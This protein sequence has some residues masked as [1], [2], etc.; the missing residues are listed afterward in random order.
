MR[1]LNAASAAIEGTIVD[2]GPVHMVAEDYHRQSNALVPVHAATASNLPVAVPAGSAQPIVVNVITQSPADA[3]SSKWTPG[4][5]IA[6]GVVGLALVVVAVAAVI[7]LAPIA[8]AV[9]AAVI[10]L[11]RALRPTPPAAAA[12]KQRRR[13]W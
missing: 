7:V 4:N 3:S 10:F 12:P 8:V 11:I 13:L 5:V 2:H 9:A 6:A 1:H